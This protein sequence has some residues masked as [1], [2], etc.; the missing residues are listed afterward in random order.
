MTFTVK[1]AVNGW[2]VELWR[3]RAK[4]EE[5]VFVTREALFEFLGQLVAE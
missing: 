1:R 2:T 4:V 5:H 3:D